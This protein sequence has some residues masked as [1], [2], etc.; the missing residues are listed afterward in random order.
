MLGRQVVIY[1]YFQ[2]VI[3]VMNLFLHFSG[4]DTKTGL[5]LVVLKIR[6]LASELK[7]RPLDEI[8]WGW[9]RQAAF[10]QEDYHRERPFA[11]PPPSHFYVGETHHWLARRETTPAVMWMGLQQFFM[12]FGAILWVFQLS[13]ASISNISSEHPK[14]TLF[15]FR[16]E[17][18]VPLY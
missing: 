13:Q 11:P 17:N 7:I 9:G 8:D 2:D 5:I 10:R 18:L 6:I 15:S 1:N 12:S 14:R 16:G 3:F 4:Y